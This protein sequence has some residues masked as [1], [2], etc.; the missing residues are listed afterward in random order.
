[1]KGRG[2]R[3]EWPSSLLVLLLVA[4][5]L[6]GAIALTPGSDSPAA[7]YDGPRAEFAPLPLD[8]NLPSWNP[9][10]ECAAKRVTIQD[11]LGPA[12]P[13]Q[14]VTGAPYET[15][16]TRGD[17]GGHTGGIPLKRALSPPCAITNIS[18]QVQGAFV[19]IDGVYLDSWHLEPFDCSNQ[20]RRYNGG[21]LHPG[22]RTICDSQGDIYALGSTDGFVRVGIDQDWMARGY[23]GPGISPCDN[24]TIGDW[25]S[26]GTI[27]LDVQG[28]VYWD[29]ENW[30]IHSTTGV[31]LSTGLKVSVDTSSVQTT[32]NDSAAATVRVY[33]TETGLV[34]LSVSGCPADVSCAFVP[35]NGLS[36]FT[37]RF[38]VN[39]TPASP[40][41]TYGLSISATNGSLTTT[42]PFQLVI[43]DRAVRTFVRGDGGFFSETD[44]LY[45][46]DGSPNTN[47]GS[48]IML[49][50]D[51]VGCNP[52]GGVCKSLIKFPSIFG[53]ASGQIPA[54]SRIVDAGLGLRITNDGKTQTGYQVTERWDEAT[55]T[56]NGFHTPG[57]PGNRGAEFTFAP[58]PV[59]P[60]SLNITSIVQRWADG[61]A[62]PGILLSSTHGNGVDYNASE[63]V[64]NRPTLRVQFVPPPSPLVFAYD[65]ETLTSDGRMADRSG[66]GNQGTISGA[67]DVVGR[68]GR[69]REFNGTT[70]YIEVPD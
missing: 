6:M 26:T 40:T 69:G 52:P 22:N 37:S 32:K 4:S 63:S 10:V 13:G 28:F 36:R 15:N 67:T 38:I 60:L 68:I 70:D 45:I 31:R 42:V 18:G 27:S 29:G 14:S 50:I 56:W 25:V 21:G 24:V 62:N 48:D 53:Q 43:A 41:G 35:S 55:A 44:D 34:S 58:N 16:G 51:A 20:Y 9:N 11:I 59:G 1:M 2:G 23:C 5:A 39:T 12:Y 47:F 19:E 49:L 61:E 17:T 8:D 30:G 54:G 66:N 7:P 46:S 57:V 64:R 3:R 65:M 33:G